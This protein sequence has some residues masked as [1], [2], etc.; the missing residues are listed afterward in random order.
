M[1]KSSEIQKRHCRTCEHHNVKAN[2]E[3]CLRCAKDFESSMWQTR[4]SEGKEIEK[5]TI[6]FPILNNLTPNLHSCTLKVIEEVG[7]LM[8]KLGKGQGANGETVGEDRSKWAVET[9]CEA[10]DTAQSAIT[11]ADTLC[12]EY[13]FDLEELM[14]LHESKLKERGYLK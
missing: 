14:E 6:T 13:S 8:E 11:L 12:K 3:P 10:M 9:V 7:E 4:V 5:K 2:M 1:S